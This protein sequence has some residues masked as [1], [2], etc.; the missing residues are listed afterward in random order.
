MKRREAQ[1]IK[2]QSIRVPLVIPRKKAF[3]LVAAGSHYS[4]N[5][6]ADS[7]WHAARRSDATLA[8]PAIALGQLLV[9]RVRP[10]TEF[11][12]NAVVRDGLV[13]HSG[14]DTVFGSIYLTDGAPASQRMTLAR[15]R[16]P[17]DQKIQDPFDP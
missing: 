1:L 16:I 6:D 15:S 13:E 5:F 8:L 4:T 11:F 17:A 3:P 12:D 9:A 7:A 10:A 2:L 14:D